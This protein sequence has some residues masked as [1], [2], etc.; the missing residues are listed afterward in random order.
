MIRITQDQAEAVWI[1]EALKRETPIRYFGD[2]NADF[3]YAKNRLKELGV[4][5]EGEENQNGPN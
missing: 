3:K 1:V 2:W 5:I 4:E